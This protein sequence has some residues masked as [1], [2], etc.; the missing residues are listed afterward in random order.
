MPSKHN[1]GQMFALVVVCA[2]F[3]A[4]TRSVHAHGS[5]ND[6]IEVLG[7]AI[8]REPTHVEFLVERA[9]LYREIGELSHALADYERALRLDPARDSLHLARALTLVEQGD[10]AEAL[11]SV[12]TFI[13]R[14]P[15]HPRAWRVR[16]GALSALHR[17]ADA[18]SSLNCAIALAD[19]PAPED[20]LRRAE[21]LAS[22]GPSS[23]DIAIAGLDDGLEKLGPAVTLQLFAVELER[24]RGTYDA[25]LTRLDEM[26]RQYDRVESVLALRGD[27]LAQAGRD[28]EA[29]AA[30]TDAL[31]AIEE[32]LSHGP[33]T[34]AARRLKAE[35]LHKLEI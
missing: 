15:D 6:R 12:D 27:I 4:G 16:A 13:D 3:H 21:L 23:L 28:Q 34:P 32:W 35:L 2:L 18:I 20:Y 22:L 33:T 30:Y 9:D 1:A 7:V 24:R 11:V 25:A 10:F 14:D 5:A 31:Q 17:V 26:Q 29:D 8:A 19:P